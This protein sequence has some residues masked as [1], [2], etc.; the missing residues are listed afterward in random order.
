MTR[1]R[2]IFLLTEFAILYFGVPLLVLNQERWIKFSA[3]WGFAAFAL[4]LLNRRYDV[5]WRKEWNFGAVRPGLP[6][7]AKRA[8]IGSAL[9]VGLLFWLVPERLLSFPLERPGFWA[10]VM[11]LYPLLSALPQELVYRS[12]LH[13]R[14]GP[15]FPNKCLMLAMAGATFGWAHILFR[16]EVAVLLCFAGGVMFSQTY[17]KH[18]SLALAWLEHSFYGCFIFTLGLGVYFYGMSIR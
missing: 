2:Q 5:N 16:N 10:V 11:L 6:Q 12:L 9:L 14:Y 13:H 3:L 17:L 7:V 15:L 1:P 4:I 18:R 8:L